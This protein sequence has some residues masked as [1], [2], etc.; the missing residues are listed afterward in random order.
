M[1]GPYDLFSGLSCYCGIPRHRGDPYAAGLTKRAAPGVRLL[2]FGYVSEAST[3]R[4]PASR[5]TQR[6]VRQFAG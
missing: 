4:S 6:Q 1:P 3:T 2:M 5:P